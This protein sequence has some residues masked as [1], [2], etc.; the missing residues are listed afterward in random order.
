MKGLVCEMDVPPPVVGGIFLLRTR[1]IRN[2]Q[3]YEGQVARV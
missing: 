3:A 1:L 2:D